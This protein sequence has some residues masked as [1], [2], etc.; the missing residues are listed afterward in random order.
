MGCIMEP[1]NEDG[2]EK[3]AFCK[4]CEEYLWA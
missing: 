2:K 4:D 1:P 3:K